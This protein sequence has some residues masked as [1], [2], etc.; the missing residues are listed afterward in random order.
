MKK[1]ALFASGTGSNAKTIIDYFKDHPNVYADC[2][3]S[4]KPGAKALEMAK[5][6]G[7]D[8]RVIHKDELNDPSTILNY[9]QERGIDL[10]VLAGYLKRIP[11]EMVSAFPNRI[12][13]IHPA[14]LP[15]FGGKG[16][17]G[18]NVHK[19][20]VEA[21]EKQSGMTIHYVN[22]HYDEGNIIF[23]ASCSLVESDRPE[24]VA[25]KVLQLEHRHYAEVIEKLLSE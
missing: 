9:L 20:V 19:A 11:K 6:K 22:E 12:I 1:I 18:M 23:Q 16:M 7:L 10:I 5:N 24:D 21:G 8:T 3:L 17:Y 14:L 25:A 2:L 15:K 13:N 4:N